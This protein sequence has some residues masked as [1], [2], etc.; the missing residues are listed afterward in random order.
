[1][2]SSPPAGD[3]LRRARV[4]L[5]IVLLVCASAVSGFVGIVSMAAASFSGS[6]GGLI[7]KFGFRAFVPGLFYGLHCVFYHRFVLVFPIVQRPPFFSYK[8]GLRSA[9]RQALK[10]SVAASLL[11]AAFALFL[12]NQHE[13]QVGGGYFVHH[14]V[15]YIG[16]FAVM[17]SWELIIHLHKV[18]HTKRF[19]FA[20]LEGYAAIDTNPSEPLLSVLGESSP[21]SLLQYLAY[22]DLSMVCGSNVDPWRRAAFFEETGDTYKRVVSQCLKPLV[23]LASK[24]AEGLNSA[25]NTHKLSHQL[26]SPDDIRQSSEILELF[27]DFQLY[28][29]CAQAIASLE[30]RS[31]REDKFGV[32]QLSGSHATVLSTLLSCLLA[33]ET[34]MGK[35]SNLQSPNNMLG[36]GGIKWATNSTARRDVATTLDKKRAGPFRSK[37]YALADVLKTSIYMIISEFHEEMVA[38][39]KLGHLEKYWVISVKPIYG[40][41]DLLVQKLHFFLNFQAS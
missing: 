8:M 14:F 2:G 30:T 34:F 33:V 18:L 10:L 35:K 12:P 28:A 38:S 9:I 22:L 40:S 29:W 7:S 3:F 25:D 27:N 24:L 36:P 41:V 21:G 31:H 37:S 39:A 4:S 17:L 1:M 20:P 15:F 32:A 23:Q 11:S 26:Y 5:S 13:S 6:F 19:V 16:S